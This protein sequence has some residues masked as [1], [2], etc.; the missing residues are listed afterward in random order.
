MGWV[1]LEF[2]FSAAHVALGKG[3]GWVVAAKGAYIPTKNVGTYAPPATWQF[4][5][6]TTQLNGTWGTP[7]GSGS[8]GSF[9]PANGAYPIWSNISTETCH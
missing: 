6:S 1:E 5:G 7:N 3:R 8:A 2:P 4:S 9:T